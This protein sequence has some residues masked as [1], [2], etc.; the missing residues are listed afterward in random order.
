MEVLKQEPSLN[1]TTNKGAVGGIQG[2]QNNHCTLPP[3]KTKGVW[4]YE[5]MCSQ[6]HFSGIPGFA[7]RRPF[8]VAITQAKQVQKLHLMRQNL[9]LMGQKPKNCTATAKSLYHHE[10]WIR[11]WWW[12]EE[13]SK[14]KEQAAPKK[15]QAQAKKQIQAHQQILGST[16]R[17][18]FPRCSTHVAPQWWLVGLGHSKLDPFLS[19]VRGWCNSF[20]QNV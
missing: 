8:Q 20:F 3:E 2:R 4:R 13:T 5:A 1:T 17:C 15:S 16:M 6:A 11:H 12:H 10:R 9:H 7:I 18:T 14:P 19:W